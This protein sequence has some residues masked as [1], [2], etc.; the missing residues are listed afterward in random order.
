MNVN[1]DMR[2]VS[3]KGLEEFHD[4]F[5]TYGHKLIEGKDVRKW[6]FQPGNIV[7]NFL[8]CTRKMVLIIGSN[9]F[10]HAGI[11]P[12]IADKYSIKDLNRLMNLYLWDELSNNAKNGKFDDIFNSSKLSPL[13][14]RTYGNI[15]LHKTDD[16]DDVNKTLEIYKV[17]KVG[18]IYVGHTPMLE[19]GIISACDKKLYFTDIGAS[20]AFDKF[21]TTEKK[22]QVLEILNDITINILS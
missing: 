4:K 6:V 11:V 19:E 8:A 1:G 15:G 9:L 21:R 13:W 5:T 18:R 10:V 3:H 20:G 2:Y 14:T 17:Y 16:C 12:E 22:A 7:S